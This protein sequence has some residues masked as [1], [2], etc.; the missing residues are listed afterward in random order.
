MGWT[1]CLSQVP[2][3]GDGL[4]LC[5]GVRDSPAWASKLATPR[6][7]RYTLGLFA[8]PWVNSLYAAPLTPVLFL[9]T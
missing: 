9:A 5:L 7:L 4:T 6:I 3:L 1:G 8:V 2:D